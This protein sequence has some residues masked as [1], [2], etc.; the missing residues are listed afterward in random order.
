MNLRTPASRHAL[1]STAASLAGLFLVATLGAG[2]PIQFAPGKSRAQ[3]GAQE[4]IPIGKT[5]PSGSV[6]SSNP[7]DAIDPM[8]DFSRDAVR[9]RDPKEEKRQKNARL[10]KQNWAALEPGELQEKDDHETEFG[11]RNYN[12]S[13]LEKDKGGGEIWFGSKQERG[14]PKDPAQPGAP[15]NR[16]RNPG[17]NKLQARPEAEGN[18]ADSGA[19]KVISRET[20]TSSGSLGAKDLRLNTLIRSEQPQGVALNEIMGRSLL[21]ANAPEDKAQ[22]QESFG[23]RS[24]N[25]AAANNASGLGQGLG[26]GSGLGKDLSQRPTLSSPASAPGQLEGL[27]SG[28]R[29][30]LF[31]PGGGPPRNAF[32]SSAASSASAGYQNS[33][34]GNPPSGFSPPQNELSGRSVRDTFGLPPKPGLGTR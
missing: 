31:G 22:G 30:G 15:G 2:E 13:T 9:R 25:P 20:D 3:P 24:L 11:I 23:L 29:G 26:S 16:L 5:T 12:A 27:G 34:F 7:S 17:P 18:E 10:Q 14:S 6:I 33:G 19:A 4:K 28:G 32:S 8:N 1:G 21:G